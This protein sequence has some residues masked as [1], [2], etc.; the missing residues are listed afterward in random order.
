[1]WSQKRSNAC[2]SQERRAVLG[3]TPGFKEQSQ[4]HLIHAPKKIT[5]IITE[6]IEINVTI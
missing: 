5:Y 3:V 6:S 1:M 2:K 4:V